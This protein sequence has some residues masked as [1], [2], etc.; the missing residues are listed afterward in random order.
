MTATKVLVVDDHAVVRDGLCALLEGVPDVD[1]VGVAEDGS[2]ALVVAR[3]TGPDVVLMD[4]TMPVMDG[5]EATRRLANG[6][7]DSPAVLVLTMS[8]DD[9]SLLAAIRAGARGYLLKDAGGDEVVAG[10]R[11]VARGEAVFGRRVAPQVLR[12][13]Q[14]PVSETV[15]FPQLSARERE[16]L[17]LVGRGLGNQAIGVRLGISTKTV[18]NAVSNLLVKLPAR[19]RAEAV[20]MARTEGLA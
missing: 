14:T 9:A 8:D 12:L 16:V 13:L 4:L 10:I 2:R 18:A 19:D 17:S 20:A 6:G 7:D 5:A 1:V 11:A 15:P 3:E